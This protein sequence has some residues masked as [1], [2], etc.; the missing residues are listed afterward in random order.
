M[1]NNFFN[2]KIDQQKAQEWS[3]V[4]QA[5]HIPF[6][7]EEE[8]KEYNFM[9]PPEFQKEAHKQI[10]LYEEENRFHAINTQL[11]TPVDSISIIFIPFIFLVFHMIVHQYNEKYRFIEL[12]S[13]SSLSILKG[14]WWR[15]V[16]ALTLHSGFRHIAGNI[17]MGIIIVNSLF[18]FTG[19]GLAWFTVLLSGIFG[20]LINA[21]MHKT[22]FISIGSSTAVFGA[23]GVLSGILLFNRLKYT[24]R[25]AVVPFA[26][27]VA[28]LGITGA[29][30]HTDIG[31]HLWGFVSG[32][33]IGI[34]IALTI[35][36]KKIPSK[37]TQIVFITISWLLPFLAWYIAF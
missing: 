2:N 3:L 10:L 17:V 33:I 13:A 22:N 6:L 25:Q 21:L 8:G 15:L 7:L 30:Q 28:L 19:V 12:G 11:L 32:I 16:T 26:G 14:E 35:I 36:R 23:L 20:N 24:L 9:I 31:G 5:M 18:A 37:K 1:E 4:F 29:G 27:A 34:I